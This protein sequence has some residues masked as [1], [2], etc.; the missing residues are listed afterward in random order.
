MAEK[1]ITVNFSD[2]SSSGDLSLQLDEERN[3]DKTTFAVGE[4]AYLK[5]LFSNSDAYTIKTSSGSASVVGTNIHYPITDEEIQFAN[6]KQ[7][8]L[9][10]VPAGGVT[11]T[12][13]G[14]NGGTPLFNEKII[15]VPNEI[16]GILNCDYTT[17]GDRLALTAT[18]SGTILVVVIQ[19]SNQA[20]LAVTFGAAADAVEYEL[21]VKDFCSDASLSGVAVSMDG[22]YKGLTDANGVV[23]L[24]LLTPGSTHALK[25]T[26]SGYE[27]SDDDDLNNDSFVVV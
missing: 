10:Y 21:E 15:T 17:K 22:R 20:S 23:N 3:N 25:M 24:G 5:F 8:T 14:N 26:R 13:I 27:D 2:A 1:H 11:P 18:E 4:I 12:W 19:G 7:G 9:D 6:V 16:I